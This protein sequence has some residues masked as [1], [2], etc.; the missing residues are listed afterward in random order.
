MGAEHII[1][2][3]YLYSFALA[4]VLYLGLS[5][6]FPDPSVMCEEEVTGEEVIAHYDDKDV[7]EA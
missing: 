5:Y 2:L 1:A 6:A 3:G 7:L 4:G